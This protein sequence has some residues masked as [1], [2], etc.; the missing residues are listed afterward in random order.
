MRYITITT[1]E[2]ADGTDY[3]VSLRAIEEKRLPALKGLGA[4]RVTVI[5]T[6]ERT[7]AA[8]T[9]WPDKITRDA[10]ELKIDEVRRKVHKEDM[11]RMT[12]EMRGEVVADV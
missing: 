10:A 1:W 5:R 8:I 2:I 6:S 4:S 3:N 11:T 9:E 7:S 12:G